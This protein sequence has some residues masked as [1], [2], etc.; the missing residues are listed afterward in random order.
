VLETVLF[1]EPLTN[2]NVVQQILLQKS[3]S[4]PEM[5]IFF[6]KFCRHHKLVEDLVRFYL[7]KGISPDQTA[8][9]KGSIR[10]VV[11]HLS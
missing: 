10:D 3:K 9:I 5:A 2:L 7:G 11:I 8:A 4:N 6:E 1:K